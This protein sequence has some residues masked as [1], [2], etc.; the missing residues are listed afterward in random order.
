MKSPQTD[1]EINTATKMVHLEVE[2][3]KRRQQLDRESEPMAIT[4]KML[5]QPGLFL[6]LGLLVLFILAAISNR[7]G[8]FELDAQSNRDFLIWQDEKVV[9]WDM[10]ILAK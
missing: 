9:N 10:Q 7:L 4:N 8:Y 6:S 2:T 3:D 5:E 1:I